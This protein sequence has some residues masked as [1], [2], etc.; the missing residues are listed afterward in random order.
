MPDMLLARNAVEVIKGTN[1]SFLLTV[2]KDTGDPQS[3]AGGRVVL[4]VREALDSTRPVLVKTSDSSLQIAITDAR[5][6]KATI[7]FVPADTRN[8]EPK[9]YVFDV[10]VQLAGGER[11]AVIPPT[12]L[13]L[14]LGVTTL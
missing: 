14:Q 1:R 5:G 12:T 9:Q 11:Y 7:Y 13:D 2:T 3:L 4:T 10:W 8:L 6:G